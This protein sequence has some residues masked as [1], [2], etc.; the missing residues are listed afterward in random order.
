[1]PGRIRWTDDELEVAR[2]HT[3]YSD[4]PDWFQ[5]ERSFAGFRQKR[6]EHGWGSSAKTRSPHLTPPPDLTPQAGGFFS[7]KK[8]GEV[9]WRDYVDF[10]KSAQEFKQKASWSQDHGRIHFDVDEPMFVLAVSDFHLGSWGTDYDTL[11][12]VTEEILETPNLYLMILGDMEQM[13]IKL[14]NV[15]EIS[16]NLL[17]TEWQIDM[18]ESWVNDVADKVIA[19]LWD[20]H[21]VER[22]EAVT[23]RSAYKRLMSRKAIYHNGIGHLDV[24][25]GGETYRIAASHKFRG[26]SELN[27]LHA[28]MKYARFQAQDREII[29]AGD[30]HVPGIAKY[31][32]GDKVRLALNAG[33]L[34]TNSGYAK[35]YFS[36]STHPV[37]PGFTLHP[38]R[39]VFTPFWSVEEWLA[40]QG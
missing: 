34:Q 18:L 7:D 21:S 29:M 10:A 8:I 35:R 32:D 19:A 9:G 3:F 36:L 22:E 4:T 33:T 17:P 26:R 11:M 6:L 15:L 16:D 39:H 28:Q 38:D 12:R 1:M 27:P 23:G 14:R 5:T 37:M 40:S 25:V 31:V 24:T 13:S 20:N 2:T 30:S